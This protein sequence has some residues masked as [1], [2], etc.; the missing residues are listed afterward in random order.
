MHRA[1]KNSFCETAFIK[2]ILL[3]KKFYFTF[4]ASS[5]SAVLPTDRNS[6]G[7]NIAR[8]KLSAKRVSNFMWRRTE[9]SGKT[10][11]TRIKGMKCRRDSFLIVKCELTLRINAAHSLIVRCW[12]LCIVIK[13]TSR[14]RKVL[15]TCDSNGPQTDDINVADQESWSISTLHHR[16]ETLKKLDSFV[17][18]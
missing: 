4:S 3:N 9:I 11:K 18:V 12:T 17:V 13:V 1:L 6:Y 15:S 16:N 14:R 8:Y 10:K 2:I 5:L 7:M